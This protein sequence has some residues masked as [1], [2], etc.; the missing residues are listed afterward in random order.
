MEITEPPDTDKT[1][2]HCGCE[3]AFVKED[4]QHEKGNPYVICPYCEVTVLLRDVA[5]TEE[6]YEES[7]PYN[8]GCLVIAL[9]IVVLLAALRYLG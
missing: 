7:D 6:E 2:P 8:L 5:G 4:I 1:C 3:F 9:A